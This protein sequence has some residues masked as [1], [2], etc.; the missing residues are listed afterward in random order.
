MNKRNLIYAAIIA[1]LTFGVCHTSVSAKNDAQANSNNDIEAIS[2]DE[3][4]IIK[5]LNDEIN[6]VVEMVVKA[7]PTLTNAKPDE[8]LTKHMLEV[9]RIG[10][11][12]MQL[13]QS[14]E[15]LKLSEKALAV[16]TALKERRT[17]RYMLWAEMCLQ[18]CISGQYRDLTKYSQDDRVRIYDRLSNINIDIIPEHILSRE[19]L[20]QLNRIYDT[21]DEAH[22]KQ[23]RISSIEK[24][25][26]P[27]PADTKT[28]PRKMLENF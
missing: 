28:E 23:V 6:R 12:A 24:R 3:S 16:L 9:D 19:I 7:T 20:S 11:E 14:D 8:F 2:I 10:Q 21:L 4:E 5:R 22:K 18:E 15:S 27:L 1:L 17:Y 13:P 26:G 25:A